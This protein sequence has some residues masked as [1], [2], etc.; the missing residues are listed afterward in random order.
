M[1]PTNLIV[2]IGIWLQGWLKGLLANTNDPELWVRIIS[3]GAG[4]FILGFVP[5]T[6]MFFL[7]WYER[8]IVARIGDRLGPNNTTPGALGGPWGL[9]QVPADAIKMFTKE[10]MIPALA[11]RWVFNIAPAVIMAVAVLTWAVIPLGK[12]VIGTD[13]SIGV[14][15]ILSIGSGGMI[16]I[17]MAGWGSNNKYAL[18]AALRGIATLIGYEIPQV[19]SVMAVVMLAGS[20]SLQEVVKSQDVWYILAMPLTAMLFFASILSELGRR[21]FDLVEADSEIVAGYFIE[22]SGMKFGMFYLAEFMN[23]LM[24]SVL[25]STLFL[26]GWRGP[27]VNEV[28]VLGTI[29]LVGKVFFVMLVIQFFQYSIPRLR[30]D[31]ILAVNWKFL[32][33]LALVNICV[34]ALLGKAMESYGVTGSWAQTGVFLLANVVMALVVFVILAVAGR[35]ARLREETRVTARLELEEEATPV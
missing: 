18:L 15:Y 31:Q 30:I 6:S 4:A 22:Y 24:V 17:L 14:F 3:L 11:D 23:Q 29:W 10:D 34:I 1:D 7:V 33:P 20:F 16:A 2:E 32:T 35:Q 27:F 19:L 25:F 26:G 5:L 12:G 9:L 28:P 21:P 8:K 13:L